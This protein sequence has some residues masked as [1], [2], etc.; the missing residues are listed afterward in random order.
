MR[1]LMLHPHDIRYHPWTIRIIKLA[2]ELA[3]KSHSVTVGF[4]EHKRASEPDFARLR[5]I[6]SGPVQY[7]PL[8]ARDNQT[9]RNIL[10]VISLAR[11]V[12]IIHFQK[13]F[14][15]TFIPALWAS[16]RWG[17]PL[18]YDWDDNET[19]ILREIHG[20]PPGFLSQAKFLEKRIPH[21]ADTISVSSDGLLELCLK[22]GFPV[23]RIR[24]VP[25]GADL[26]TFNPQHPRENFRQ[27]APFLV[28]ER[29]LVV[30]IGQLE[31]AAYAGLFVEAC[32]ILSE[33]FPEAVWMV[34][35]GGPMLPRLKDQAYQLNLSHR[36]VFTD[37]LPSDRIP[38]VLAAADI[39]VACFSDEG[40]VRCKSPLKVAEYM[41]AGKAIVASDVGEVPWMTQG[42]AVLV[43]PGDSQALAGG[44][45]SLLE[46]PSLREELG[47]KARQRAET[48]INWQQS[49]EKL[50]EAYRLALQTESK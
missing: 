25:V 30:Y 26:E 5:E 17:K 46:N 41:A 42:A 47:I 10:D 27:E 13:C 34:V 19:L 6:P 20:L 37:Y 7:V 4:I 43:R 2:E 31:G 40:F 48:C 16:W 11:D 22:C 44:I 24:K 33:K 32:G 38:D 29:P 8:R 18:H 23:E 12:D 35:G 14:A 9:H 3:R 28:G 1:I 15:S 39:A 45:Q 50:E 49:A 21:Y 36:V